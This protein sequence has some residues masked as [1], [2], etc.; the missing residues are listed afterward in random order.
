MPNT[1]ELAGGRVDRLAVDHHDE[2]PLAEL[3]NQLPIFIPSNDGHAI[4]GE[5][6]FAGLERVLEGI[7]RVVPVEVRILAIHLPVSFEIVASA[8]V[9]LASTS[10]SNA[11]RVK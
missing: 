2:A 7:G 11:L 5:D 4:R 1:F 9:Y 6:F 3:G 8:Y 10:W